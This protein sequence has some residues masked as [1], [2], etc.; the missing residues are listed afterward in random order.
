MIL[1]LLKV[2]LHL[3]VLAFIVAIDLA[4]YY[5]GIIVNNHIFNSYRLG[6]IHPCYQSFVLCL[7]IGRREIN[8]DHAFNLIPFLGVEYCLLACWE[9]CS[10]GCSIVGLILPLGLP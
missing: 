8:T 3:F 5:L 7:D 9:I 2:A 10:Y 6:E 4:S 1:H